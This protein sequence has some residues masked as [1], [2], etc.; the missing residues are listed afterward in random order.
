VLTWT[1][2]G[3]PPARQPADAGGFGTRLAEATV[4]G[5]FGGAIERDWRPEGIV[6]RITMPRR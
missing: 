6:I 4:H 2:R 1:E 3:G 5:Q